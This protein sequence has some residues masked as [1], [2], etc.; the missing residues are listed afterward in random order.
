[1][2]RAIGYEL[3]VVGALA[4]A[5]T[6]PTAAAAQVTQA[7]SLPPPPALDVPTVQTGRLAN[8]IELYVVPMRE[9]PL[10]QFMLLIPGGGRADGARTG[11]ASFTAN[12][13]DEGADTLDAFGIAAQAA[14]LG[15][16]LGTAADWDYTIVSMKAPKRT[17]EAALD[18]MSDVVLR[19][20]FASG[21]VQRQRDLRLAAILQQRD[22]PDAVAGL[23]Y[24]AILFPETHPYH[25][26]LTGDSASTA[27]LDS[28]VVRDFYRR[29]YGPAGAK[30]VVTGDVSAQE[31]QQLAQRYFGEW[32]GSGAGAAPAAPSDG[33][34]DRATSV[35]LVDKPGAAQ[36]VIR[37]GHA[38]V[39]RSNPDFAALEVMNTILGGSFSSRLNFNLR[40]TKGYTYG[41]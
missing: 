35:F 8:G 25:H 13:L 17:V 26:S 7:P 19:P 1:M 14:Y 9:V 41:A 2:R 21:E 22:Q 11:L 37:I 12:M 28:A 4:T 23:A 31:A 36:S 16:T 40:E 6:A 39:A 33:A 3:L 15:A 10:V 20:T 24:G 29:H 5:L 30:L 34:V 27:A 38:G 32:S 18:L